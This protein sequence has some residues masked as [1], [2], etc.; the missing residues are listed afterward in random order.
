MSTITETR[1]ATPARILRQLWRPAAVVFV[2]LLA[3]RM[4][5]ITPF[6]VMSDSM[7]PTLPEGATI[8]VDRLVEPREVAHQDLVLFDTAEG[9]VVK[10][11]VG[12][13]GD[14]IRIHDAVLHVN[15]VPVD[16]PYVD[17]ITLDGVFFGPVT[18]PADHLFVLGDN[19][20]DSIDSRDYGPVPFSAING[21]VLGR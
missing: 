17:E 20:F 8:Y 19:R 12:L 11:V 2:L 18:V 3:V 9:A 5:V 4:W 1:S 14:Q 15:G 6:E 7:S 16:E 21:R 13:P 10:R